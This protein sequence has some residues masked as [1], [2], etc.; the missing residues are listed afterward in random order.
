MIN[1]LVSLDVGKQEV[2]RERT[3]NV[4]EVFPVVLYAEHGGLESAD[5]VFDTLIV[6]VFFNDSDEAIVRVDPTDRPVAG[7]LVAKFEASTDAFR[8]AP[9]TSPQKL[10][11]ESAIQASP[12]VLYGFASTEPA[13]PYTGRSG[14]AGIQNLKNPFRLRR[15]DPPISV[16]MGKA[17]AGL[18]ANKAGQTRVISNGIAFYKG[19][20]I[21]I[22]S[23]PSVL[24]IT[25]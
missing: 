5:L 11:L 3:A 9:V 23:I 15:G 14:R 13:G 20:T 24:R 2:V 1:L 16:A 10:T 21:P 19:D 25:A 4:G 22:K 7:S 6:E 8:A 18:K 17:T 12:L